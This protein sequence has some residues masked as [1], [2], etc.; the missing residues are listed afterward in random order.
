M[1]SRIH[2]HLHHNPICRCPIPIFPASTAMT[3]MP[4]TTLGRPGR[5]AVRALATTT[6]HILTFPAFKVQ[7]HQVPLVPLEGIKPAWIHVHARRLPRLLAPR[8]SRIK[9]ALNS[10]EQGSAKA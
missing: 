5:I 8:R 1:S 9:P 6:S 3:R 4:L 7:R 10:R 2:H